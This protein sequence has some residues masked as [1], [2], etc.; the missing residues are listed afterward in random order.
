VGLGQPSGLGPRPLG[1]IGLGIM[2]SAMAASLLRAGFAVAGYDVL[3]ARRRALTRAGGRAVRSCREI[4]ARAGLVICSLPTSDALIETAEALA[5]A[6]RTPRLVVD[7]STLPVEVKQAARRR[8]RARGSVVLDCPIS[9]TGAQARTRDLVVYASG[10]RAA[11][12]EAAAVID[13][14]ARKQYYVGPFG[15][16]STLKIVA[17][18]LVAIHNVA[19]AEALVLAKRAG[20][21]PVLAL[22]ALLDG[23]GYSRMLELRGPMM[24]AGDYAR[25]TMKLG[26]WQKDLAL[27]DA[28]AR[29]LRCPTPLFSSSAALYAEAIGSGRTSEDT[30]AVC[31]VLERLARTGSEPERSGWRSPARTL[32]PPRGERMPH[33][34]GRRRALAGPLR[35]GG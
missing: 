22:R 29:A 15:A 25:A 19:A 34:A 3:A 4:A 31:R 33:P 12:R 20:L 10:P 7:T 30:A 13:A 24:V 32:A 5:S 26:V 18:L 2:G 6:P 9:G 17:N 11:C 8:L 28:F 21:D 27:I 35:P 14:F 16:G 23:A 1:L